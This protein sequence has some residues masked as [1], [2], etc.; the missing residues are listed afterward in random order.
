MP[1]PGGVDEKNPPV[2]VHADPIGTVLHQS[3][4][5]LLGQPLI[6]LPMCSVSHQ[7]QYLVSDL[8]K[9]PGGHS[10]HAQF[11]TLMQDHSAKRAT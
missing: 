8:A 5:S 3:A 1:E 7:A 11:T 10:H 4:V 6:G 2:L 9:L